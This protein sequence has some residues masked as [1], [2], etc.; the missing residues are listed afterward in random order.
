[1]KQY[2]KRVLPGMEK[3]TVYLCVAEESIVQDSDPRNGEIE[4]K[5][6]LWK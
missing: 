2:Q 5:S 6:L 1:M 4:G 3:Y